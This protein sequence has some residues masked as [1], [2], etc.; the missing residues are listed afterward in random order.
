VKGALKWL[1]CIATAQVLVS[2]TACSD[3]ASDPPPVKTGVATGATCPSDSTLT[4]E[5]WALDFFGNYCLRC[6]SKALA[7]GQRNGAPVGFDWD[8]IDSVRL[9]AE[10]MDLMAA[11]S[12]S[13]VNTQMPL[14]PP[15]PPT[16]ERRK[17]GEW[18]ACGAPT[19]ADR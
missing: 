9:H 2:L 1:S 4:Y 3:N 5:S 12:N 15:D 7:P 14:N 8:D 10:E 11:A 16:S 18:L 13:V 19:D 17:L 6:H